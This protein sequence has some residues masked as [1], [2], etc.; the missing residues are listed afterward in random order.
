M[1]NEFEIFSG[2]E[3]FSQRRLFAGLNLSVLLEQR[4]QLCLQQFARARADCDRN[5]LAERLYERF[6]CEPLALEGELRSKRQWDLSNGMQEVEFSAPFSGDPILW[7]C[8]PTPIDDVL[9]DGCDFGDWFL[10]PGETLQRPYGEVFR[11]Q[12]ILIRSASAPNEGVESISAIIKQQGVLIEQSNAAL[13]AHI[14]MLG[15]D[16]QQVH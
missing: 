13:K 16:T 7:E 2:S 11:G 9:P 15:R 12:I 1:R 10:P 3:I 5:V 4:A 8:S 6:I 14:A